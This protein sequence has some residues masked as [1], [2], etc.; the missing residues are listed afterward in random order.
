MPNNLIQVNFDGTQQCTT[1]ATFDTANY[2][3]LAQWVSKGILQP[4][5]IIMMKRH[6]STVLAINRS[7][8]PQVI[9]A[10]LT[11]RPGDLKVGIDQVVTMT[12]AEW[13]QV[14]GVKNYSTWFEDTVVFRPAFSSHAIECS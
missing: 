8:S 5:D 9:P 12:S 10:A 1:T 14:N 6:M 7:G 3:P 4:G 11:G 2:K 13:K